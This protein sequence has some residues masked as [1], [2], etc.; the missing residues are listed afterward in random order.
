MRKLAM[1]SAMLTLS[2]C[3]G[4]EVSETTA[5]DRMAPAVTQHAAALGGNDVA[6]M[7]RTGLDLINLFDA[8]RGPM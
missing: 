1:V 7:R 8:A 4:S 3:F 5:L 2:G 6:E